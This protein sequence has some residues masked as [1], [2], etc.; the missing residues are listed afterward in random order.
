[1]SSDHKEQ[2]LDT[3]TEEVVRRLSASTPADGELFDVNEHV[4]HQ[5]TAV[6]NNA[7]EELGFGRYQYQLFLTCGFGFLVDQVR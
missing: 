7:I 2:K 3:S 4:L 6:F 5:N 1:M